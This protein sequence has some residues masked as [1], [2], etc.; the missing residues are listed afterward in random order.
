MRAIK[1]SWS[2]DTQ[3]SDTQLPEHQNLQNHHQPASMATLPRELQA[4][5][6]D[7]LTTK[8][9]RTLEATLRVPTPQTGRRTSPDRAPYGFAQ[10]RIKN[11]LLN[12]LNTIPPL[13]TRYA[14]VRE[15]S[16]MVFKL[17]HWAQASLTPA[18]DG[19]SEGRAHLRLQPR[20]V[21][22]LGYPNIATHLMSALP[23]HMNQKIIDQCASLS[24]EH[25]Q[26]NL[27]NLGNRLKYL[28][29]AQ[30][31]Q[32]VRAILND[33][34]IHS[35][36]VESLHNN[37]AYLHEPLQQ[38]TIETLI[39]RTATAIRTNTQDD[40]ALL[41]MISVLQ[42]SFSLLTSRQKTLTVDLATRVRDLGTRQQA[43]KQFAPILSQCDPHQHAMLV[44][45]IVTSISC[46]SQADEQLSSLRALLED[47]GSHLHPSQIDQIARTLRKIA[48]YDNEAFEVFGAGFS[49]FSQAEKLEMHNAAQQ[50]DNE[51]ERLEAIAMIGA[52]T[53][54]DPADQA[55]LTTIY[56]DVLDTIQQIAPS[57]RARILDHLLPETAAKRATVT[58]KHFNT[59]AQFVLELPQ[60]FLVERM[61]ATLLR[62][63]TILE[64]STQ[65]ALFH[66]LLGEDFYCIPHNI[67]RLSRQFPLLQKEQQ[68]KI[69]EIFIQSTHILR[70]SPHQFSPE[71]VTNYCSLLKNPLSP[72]TDLHPHDQVNIIDNA[73]QVQEPMRTPILLILAK[74]IKNTPSQ[75]HEKIIHD[76]AR[77]A[78]ISQEPL[79]HLGTQIA[80]LCDI[81]RALVVSHTLQT[82]YRPGLF[83]GLGHAVRYLT[84]SERTTMLMTLSAIQPIHLRAAE[85]EPLA[86][87]L[88]K[89]D[90]GTV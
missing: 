45:S 49:C 19:T 80:H 68:H 67:E 8:D 11:E 29:A 25:P 21:W 39:E 48:N 53:P 57:D 3:P 82:P 9:L 73:L 79:I 70:T 56:Q 72:S 7:Q 2:E 26:K 77:H 42:S 23:D 88:L 59:L 52:A 35:S 28:S 66:T 31:S 34:S 38:S 43:I 85:L 27:K 55:L 32:I 20:T 14:A 37:I 44:T 86:Q 81:E 84:P 22:H 78:D 58:D 41:S 10:S 61:Q 75:M 87:G 74:H 30:Q 16:D 33:A 47:G 64:T 71:E 60:S 36:K 50:I 54:T 13:S 15:T 65:K 83:K 12:T 90:T 51:E 46:F 5:I 18:L 40:S 62:G 89:W 4:L 6:L 17:L 76:I 63:K 69:L 24:K 1:R